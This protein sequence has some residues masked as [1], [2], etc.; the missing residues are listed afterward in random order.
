MGREC[1]P[2]LCKCGTCCDPP[3]QPTLRQLNTDDDEGQRCQ[4]DNI[5]MGR[6]VK[7]LVA[8]SDISGWGCFNKFA[9]NKGDYIGEYVGEHISTEEAE[10]RGSIADQ[11]GKSYIFI[12][13]CDTD[14]DAK[15]KGNEIRFMNHADQPNCRPDILFANGMQRVGVWAN[16]VIPAQTELTINYG[17]LFVDP[18]AKNYSRKRKSS[19]A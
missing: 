10:R 14:I 7:L 11:Q 16:S 12:V 19:D 1:D 3:K 2:L 4:N 5:T 15:R 9:L 18:M 17:T 13:C 8:K 6:R